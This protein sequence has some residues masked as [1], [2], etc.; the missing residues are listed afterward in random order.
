MS[1]EWEMKWEGDGILIIP[2]ISMGL[3]AFYGM[4]ITL[5]PV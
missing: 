5:L 4:I 1:L 3:L 2:G